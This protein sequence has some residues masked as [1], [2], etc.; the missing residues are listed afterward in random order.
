MRRTLKPENL[1]DIKGFKCPVYS[2]SVNN[3]V[4]SC[5]RN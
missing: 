2:M 3:M 1:I 5:K 4:I